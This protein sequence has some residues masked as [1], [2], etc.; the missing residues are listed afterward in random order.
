MPPITLSPVSTD[1][2]LIL[3]QVRRSRWLST[4]EQNGAALPSAQSVSRRWLV[5]VWVVHEIQVL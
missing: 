3:L 4:A 5:A 2:S 1:H